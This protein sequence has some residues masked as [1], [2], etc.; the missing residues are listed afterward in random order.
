MSDS[1]MSD[2]KIKTKLKDLSGMKGAIDNIVAQAWERGYKYGLYEAK[3]S[4]NST[5]PQGEWIYDGFCV[6][7]S[8]YKCGVCRM[9]SLDRSKFCPNCGAD[10]RGGEEK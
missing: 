7:T 3:Q 9:P 1:K 10:M 5:R 6:T 8:Q 4:N 2:S